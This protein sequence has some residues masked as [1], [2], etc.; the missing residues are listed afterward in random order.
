MTAKGRHW[1]ESVR[2]TKKEKNLYWLHV[3]K[4]SFEIVIWFKDKNRVELF[5]ANLSEQVILTLKQ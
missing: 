3:F 1:W 4:D 5:M 2:G